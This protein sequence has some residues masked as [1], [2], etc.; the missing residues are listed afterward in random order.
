MNILIPISLS[1]IYSPL[2]GNIPQMA[3]KTIDLIEDFYE[4]TMMTP[5]HICQF[6]VNQDKAWIED[7]VKKQEYV[8]EF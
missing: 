5:T 1:S 4:N 3:M 8:E 2:V 7:V 6:K